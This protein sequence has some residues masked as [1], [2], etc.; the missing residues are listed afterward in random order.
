MV[1]TGD[2][3]TRVDAKNHWT[4][5][6]ADNGL[7]AHFEHTIAISDSESEILTAL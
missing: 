5:R 3:H 2:W 7:A 6:T 1:T 4:V